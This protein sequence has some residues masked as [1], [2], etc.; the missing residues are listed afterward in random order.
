MV[1]I[2]AVIHAFMNAAI[3][4]VSHAAVRDVVAATRRNPQHARPI[5]FAV[6]LGLPK[7][8]LLTLMILKT[9]S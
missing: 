9:S 2:H 8:L 3:Y 7:M 4:A 6:V 1:D 5:T